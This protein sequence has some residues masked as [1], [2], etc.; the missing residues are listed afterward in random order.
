MNDSHNTL[1]TLSPQNKLGDGYLKFQLNQQSAAILTMNNTQEAVIIP[2]E[3]ITSMPNMP[4]CVLGLMNWRSRIIWAIDLPKM[5]N[6][7]S[8][9]NRLHQYNVIVIKVESMLLG[10]V[11]QEIKGIAKF[12]PDEIRSPIGQ[13][14]S[15]LVP[16]LRGCVA[17]QEEIFL[18]LDAQAIVNSSVLV[19]N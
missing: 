16:Y 10:L 5:L 7:E 14:A 18:V 17:Q 9:D 3:S 12:M 6:L 15:S 11:V 4:D 19:G 13:V 8:L 2:V 1:A